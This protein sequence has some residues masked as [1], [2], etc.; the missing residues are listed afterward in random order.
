MP[1]E[2]SFAITP[3][4]IVTSPGTSV[5][6]TFSATLGTEP[7]TTYTAI[8]PPLLDSHVGSE[9][10]ILNIGGT[11]FPAV[12][13]ERQYVPAQMFKNP[14]KCKPLDNNK[15]R[16]QIVSNGAKPAVAVRLGLSPRRAFINVVAVQTP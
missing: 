12:D 16:L 14:E 2:K 10:I 7:G 6:Y 15:F 9:E 5:T 3:D 1:L 8:I 11:A 4:T 13:N